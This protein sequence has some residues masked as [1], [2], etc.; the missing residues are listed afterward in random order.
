[1]LRALYSVYITLFYYPFYL[2]WMILCSIFAIV[3][4]VIFGPNIGSYS[5]VIWS[6]GIC[7]ISFVRVKTYG[8]ENL[9]DNQSY[10]FVANHGGFYDIYAMYGYI[11]KNIVWMMKKELM[12]IPFLGWAC[13]LV[14]HVSVDRSNPLSAKKTIDLAKNRLQKGRSVIFFPEGSRTKTGEMGAFKRGAFVTA[15]ELELPI[16]PVTV[17]G[18]FEVMRRGTYFPKPG[19]IELHFHAPVILTD[20]K[21]GMAKEID[22]IRQTISSAY[23]RP[24]AHMSKPN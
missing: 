15:K 17:N 8:R 22:T 23:T 24:G 18:S 20:S 9:S 5:G 4:S 2:L 7:I 11:G 13:R 19:T 14:G 1:M 16:V 10:V 21:E 12:R 6:K 3:L